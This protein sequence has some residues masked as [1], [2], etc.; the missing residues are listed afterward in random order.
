MATQSK[1][2]FIAN[3]LSSLKTFG[4]SLQVSLSNDLVHLLSDQLYQSPLKA[5]EE[6]VVN[7]YDAEAKE[8]RVFVPPPSD[9]DN[10]FV[11]V[12]DNGIGMSYDGLTNLWQ[13]GRSNKR[14]DEIEK[15]HKRKQIGKFGIGKLAARTIA[16]KLTYITK[17]KD[18]ILTVTVDFRDFSDSPTGSVKPVAAP[19]HVIDDWDG[20][21]ASA[22]FSHMLSLSGIALESISGKDGKPWT[23]AILEDLTDKA[24]EIKIE[25]LE[26][27]LSTAMPLQSDF[28]LYL[29]CNEVKSS[30][31]SYEKAVEFDLSQLPSARLKRHFT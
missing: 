3:S 18:G 5:I 24:K 22:S 12:C 9:T 20:F 17:S 16:N 1:F 4:N 29:N 7:S 11:I 25:T 19:V 10:D 6:L 13:I 15:R 27:V 2:A 21:V 28:R 14:L 8:C 30:K 23:I 31:E 26:W